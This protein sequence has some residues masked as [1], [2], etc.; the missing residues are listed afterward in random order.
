MAALER[1]EKNDEIETGVKLVY[2][3]SSFGSHEMDNIRWRRFCIAY[4]WKK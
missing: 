1:K 3:F 4:D 2:A